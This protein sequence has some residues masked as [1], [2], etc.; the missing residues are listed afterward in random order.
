M[1]MLAALQRCE[2]TWSAGEIEMMEVCV[3]SVESA[4]NAYNGGASRLELCAALSEGGL[5]PTPGMLRIIKSVVKIPVFVMLRPCGGDD[6]VYS[7]HE[8]EVMKNDASVLKEWGADGFVFG[9]LTPSGDVD[10]NVCKEIMGVVSPLPAT[11][12]R[13]F[14]VCQD[15]DA[16][17]LTIIE[18]GFTRILTS[19]QEFTAHKGIPVIKKLVLNANGRI[20]IMPGAGITRANVGE[21]LRHTRAQEFH[22]SAKVLKKCGGPPNKCTMGF[23]SGETVFVTSEEIVREMLAVAGEAVRNSKWEINV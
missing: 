5:T 19:G 2:K 23:N 14:D 9:A 6:F 13:A 7:C 12:H 3:D 11:F 17:L 1:F 10:K 16:A 21:I 4:V 8:V 22:A 20:T 15:I 18:L